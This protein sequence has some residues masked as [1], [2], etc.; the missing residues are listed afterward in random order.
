MPQPLGRAPAARTAA[1]CQEP[2]CPCPLQL[3][4]VFQGPNT[5]AHGHGK[6]ANQPALCCSLF[7]ECVDQSGTLEWNSVSDTLVA[8]HTSSPGQVTASPANDRVFVVDA[9]NSTVNVFTPTGA[10]PCSARWQPAALPVAAP[11]HF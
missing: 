11:C 4:R 6:Y 8:F 2:A 10:P 5:S 1:S 9:D 7:I 3:S